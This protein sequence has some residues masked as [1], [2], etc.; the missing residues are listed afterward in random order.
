MVSYNLY[1][2]LSGRVGDLHI[3]PNIVRH[4]QLLV[5]HVIIVV[6]VEFSEA[7]STD[8]WF[9]IRGI[10]RIY[11]I[12]ALLAA[13]K[14]GQVIILEKIHV[15]SDFKR[16]G[17]GTT[18]VQHLEDWGMVHQATHIVL[19]L[20]ICEADTFGDI[21]GAKKFFESQGFLTIGPFAYKHLHLPG[22]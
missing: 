13:T 10:D 22:I 7:R 16:L 18:L 15:E 19:P 14:F 3:L 4:N 20:P 6:M 11:G 2:F 12:I 17:I 21:V 1:T 9:E 5:N 8:T